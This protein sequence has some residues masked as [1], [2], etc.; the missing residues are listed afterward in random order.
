M[1]ELP[2]AF[3]ETRVL[4]GEIGRSAVV[5]RRCGNRWYVGGIN[6]PT[7]RM[8]VLDTSFLGEGEWTCRLFRDADPS[9]GKGLGKVAVE[10]PPVMPTLKVEAAA[11]GGFAVIFEN[12]M[13]PRRTPKEH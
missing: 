1:W 11:R 13:S 7:R 12:I 4:Q 10:T 2:T 8:F 5:A 6:G 3:E 9:L